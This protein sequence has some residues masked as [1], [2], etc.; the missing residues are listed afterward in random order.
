MNLVKGF[1][2]HKYIRIT[3]LIEILEL[4]L[5]KDDPFHILG[6]AKSLFE[7]ATGAEIA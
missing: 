1:G 4:L 7:G 6:R 5:F 3:I 2:I